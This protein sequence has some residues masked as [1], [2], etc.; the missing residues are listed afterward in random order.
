VDFRQIA[1]IALALGKVFVEHS[2]AIRANV[3]GAAFVKTAVVVIDM[4]NDFA[5]GVFKSERA[6]KIIPNIKK[7]LEFERKQG[8]PIIYATDAHLPEVDHEFEV[9][10]PH[11]VKGSWGA[12][13][14]DELKP[15][16][17][18]FRVF[19]R[20]YSAF[21]GTD[22][23]MLLRELKIDTLILT[24]VVTDICVQHT[25]AD[26]FFRG[27]RVI[28]PRDC[29]EAV[30][31]PTQDTAIKFLRKAYGCEITTVD[32]LMKKKWM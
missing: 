20:K 30:D 23:D 9:W 15:E 24:G 16:K 10:G 6:A 5:T 28:V 27:Y 19:K 1:E 26:A 3:K 29:V 12:E 8:I 7:L 2:H 11:A 22:L 18:D 14:I 25:A 31:A 17:S 21:Q 32:E 4:I 13:I